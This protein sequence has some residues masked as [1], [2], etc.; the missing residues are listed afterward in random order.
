MCHSCSTLLPDQHAE[1]SSRA[2]QVPDGTK[3][4]QGR[5]GMGHAVTPALKRWRQSAQECTAVT[6]HVPGSRLAEADKPQRAR[7]GCR[8]EEWGRAAKE[9]TCAPGFSRG[10]A[11]R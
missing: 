6:G 3:A 10:S 5:A 1:N 2:E 11:A 8:A 7:C 4:R 9:H